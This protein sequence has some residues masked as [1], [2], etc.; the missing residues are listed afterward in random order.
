MPDKDYERILNYKVAITARTALR[1]KASKIVVKAA[2]WSNTYNSQH[3]AGQLDRIVKN[4]DDA[5]D[6]VTVVAVTGI[7]M[8]IG[9]AGA[10]L[11]LARGTRASY[12]TLAYSAPIIAPGAGGS[13]NVGGITMFTTRLTRAQWIKGLI[14]RG[15]LVGLPVGIGLK[16]TV[17]TS[18]AGM[19]YDVA[20]KK[21]N[22]WLHHTPYSKAEFEELRRGLIANSSGNQLHRKIL[23]NPNTDK[24]QLMSVMKK[25]VDTLV[26]AEVRDAMLGLGPLVAGLLLMTDQQQAHWYR[27]FRTELDKYLKSKHSNWDQD[28]LNMTRNALLWEFWNTVMVTMSKLDRKWFKDQEILKKEIQNRTFSMERLFASPKH[29]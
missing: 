14:T 19:V 21:I 5:M 16:C 26:V 15:L 1:Q 13:I 9:A 7:G 28:D 25:E 4:L 24:N 11:W 22:Y 2:L 12:S 27:T 10:S 6:Q 23:A 17:G 8:C 18:A 20:A 3:V 29:Q